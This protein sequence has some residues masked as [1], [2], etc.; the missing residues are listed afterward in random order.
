M[1]DVGDLVEVVWMGLLAGVGLSVT[2]SLVIAAVVRAG[3][4]RRD[5]RDGA[6]VLHSAIAVVAGLV[7]LAA[8][9]FALIT[10]LHK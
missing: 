8:V 5:G 3:T 4:A 1:S 6:A 10:M 9:A 2:F 7:C